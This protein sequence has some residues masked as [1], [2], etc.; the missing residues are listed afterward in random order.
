VAQRGGCRIFSWSFSANKR[1]R[2]AWQLGQ[3]FLDHLLGQE[4]IFGNR[5]IGM[6]FGGIQNGPQEEV[7]SK[8]RMFWSLSPGSPTTS[9]S[10]DS[11]SLEIMS[12]MV[13][14]EVRP[15]SS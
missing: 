12:R 13:L 9:P 1:E 15:V 3:K 14:W 5:D 2:F 4:R 11:S 6:L 8:K 7:F 10:P